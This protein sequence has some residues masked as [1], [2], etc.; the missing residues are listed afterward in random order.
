M[1]RTA[2]VRRTAVSERNETRGTM[3]DDEQSGPVLPRPIR[4]TA[5]T[6]VYYIYKLSLVLILDRDVLPLEVLGV[7]LFYTRFRCR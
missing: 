5:M 3:G 2:S 1:T 7:C 4:N 6:S